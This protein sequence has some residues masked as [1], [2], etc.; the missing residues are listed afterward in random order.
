MKI[1]EISQSLT[2]DSVVSRLNE[3]PKA[4]G[5]LK[6]AV[7]QKVEQSDDVDMLDQIHQYLSHDN[8]R[9]KI[10]KSFESSIKNG[11]IS[12]TDTVIH[13]MVRNVRDIQGTSSEKKEFVKLLSEGNVINTKELLAPTSTFHKI[14]PNPFARRFFRAIAT[15]G[16]GKNSKGPGEF[17]LAILSP[18]IGLAS[19]GDLEIDGK[20]IEVKA[21]VGTGGGGRLGEVGWMP[22]PDKIVNKFKESLQSRLNIDAEQADEV[23]QDMMQGKKSKSLTLSIAYLN[24]N[25][26]DKAKGI[27]A[28]VIGYMFGSDTIGNSIANKSAGSDIDFE[29]EY[30]A[31]NYKWYKDK[32]G[33]DMILTIFFTKGITLV[34]DENNIADLRKKGILRAPSVNFIPNTGRES[35][36][37]LSI[38]ASK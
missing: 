26:G 16:V 5:P 37:Q 6:K 36:T 19:K 32:S 7:I 3:A 14:I 31:Q 9:E 1:T 2:S 12:S 25:F 21:A 29:A 23:F 22:G 20:Q 33:F 28:D 38:A 8:A 4:L 13:D 35:I 24:N 11:N 15:Y 30:F 10:E 17:A 27:I 34:I 18:E